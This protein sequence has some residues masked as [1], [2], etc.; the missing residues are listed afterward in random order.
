MASR[1]AIP[2]IPVK[3]A[4]DQLPT[5]LDRARDHVLQIVTRHGRDEVALVDL[6]DLREMLSDRKF[7]TDV[8][9]RKGEATVLLPQFGIIGIG[10][11]AD[12][13][14]GDALAKL[15]EYALQ[16]LRRYDFY[17]ETDRRHLLPLVMRFLATPEDEQPGLLLEAES[18]E[19]EPTLA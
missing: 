15:R 17:R 10:E 13:A 4:K 3:E 14:A 19:A 16:Y 6:G 5:Y 12:E 7:Q 11:N 1:Y 2:S 9:I 8:S 18:T